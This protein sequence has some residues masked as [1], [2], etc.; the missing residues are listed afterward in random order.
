MIGSPGEER[1]E[2]SLVTAPGFDV[3]GTARVSEIARAGLRRVQ[4]LYRQPGSIGP[5]CLMNPIAVK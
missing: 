2:W 4:A 3:V 1:S 5:A